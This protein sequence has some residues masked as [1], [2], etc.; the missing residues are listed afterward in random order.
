MSRIIDEVTII[1]KAGDGGKGCE[2]RNYISQKK[3]IPTGGEGGR[4]GSI[5]MRSDPN[6]TS[7]KTFLYQHHFA[8]ENGGQGGSN[9]RKGKKGKDLI[10]SVP[11]GTRIFQKEKN[12]FIRDLAHAGEEVNLVEGGKGGGGNEGGKEAQPGQPG[13][14]IQIVLSLRIPADIFFVGLPNSGKSKLLNRITRAHAKEEAYPFTTKH[15]ELGIYET[16]DFKQ[17]LLCELPSIY[18]ESIHGRGVGSDFLK[19][20]E[21]AKLV[22]L[23]LDPLNQF[24]S[25]INEGQE[26]LLELLAAHDKALLNI[27]R[28]A[29]VNKMDLPEA[30]QK[31]NKEKPP[32]PVPHFLISAETGEGVEALMRYVTQ[33]IK[34]HLNA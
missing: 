19:H 23:M 34:E 33:E 15:P 8:A 16:A 14:E 28:I 17:V 30:R 4:G 10:L 7:F 26:I 2:S 25:S 21:R 1:V 29:V 12:F 9:H 31:F 6:V 13:Q 18:R 20:L 27:P 3:F 24:A 5:L 32:L 22:I 11:C